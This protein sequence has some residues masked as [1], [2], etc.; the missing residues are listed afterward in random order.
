MAT[1]TRRTRKPLALTAKT[2]EALKPDPAG[3]YYQPDLRCKGLAIRVAPDGG[4]TGDLSYR[5]KGAGV[6]RPSL[7]RFEDVGL[8]AMRRRANKLT[9]AAREGRDLIAE[10]KAVLDQHEQS[11]TVEQVVS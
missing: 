11:F 5:I 3:A 6:R 2:I 8:E 1:E 10:E 4:K 7:G 9:L